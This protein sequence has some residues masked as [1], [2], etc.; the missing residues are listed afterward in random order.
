M[1]WSSAATPMR[2]SLAAIKV[3]FVLLILASLVRPC[4]AQRRS[5]KST[6]H[7]AS[8]SLI[9]L[10]DNFP[11]LSTLHVLLDSTTEL[12]ATSD[13]TIDTT[14][15]L[16]VLSENLRSILFPTNG[17]RSANAMIASIMSRFH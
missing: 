10:P 3:A 6:L 12:R 7:S 15:R 5:I 1:L 4:T 11:D 16:I 2:R 13:Y 14:H 9:A 8:D 17:S